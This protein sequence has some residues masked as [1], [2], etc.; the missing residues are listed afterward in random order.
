MMLPDHITHYHYPDKKPFLNICDLSA[1]ELKAVVSELNERH[2]KG[3]TKRAFPDWYFL[4]RREAE[5]KLQQ[6]F[7]EKGG[8]PQRSS[9]HYFVLGKSPLL[10][11]IYN[12]NFMTVEIPLKEIR[13]ELYFSLGDSLWTM[14]ESQNPEQQWQNKWYQGHLY[15]Y[16]ETMEIIKEIQLDL[17]D[18]SSLK[19]NAIAFVETFIWSDHELHT[20]LK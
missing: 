7:R 8:N 17:G 3:E 5:L 19:K 2:R 4:Q 11:W 13:S 6:L 1:E 9:P 16:S 12:H 10:E 20:L 15:N 14:A 18:E